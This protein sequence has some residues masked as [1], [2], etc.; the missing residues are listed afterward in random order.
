M[1]VE[2]EL[3]SSKC[4]LQKQQQPHQHHH[5]MHYLGEETLTLCKGV[6][7]PL[8]LP[9]PCISCVQTKVVVDGY[10]EKVRNGFSQ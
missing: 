7:F 5:R 8:P 4:T 1:K 3:Q 6:F 9:L 2:R 10:M